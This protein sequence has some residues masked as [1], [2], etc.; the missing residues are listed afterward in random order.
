[1]KK[2]IS[3]FLSLSH[4]FCFVAFDCL[5]YYMCLCVLAFFHRDCQ[6]VSNGREEGEALRQMSTTFLDICTIGQWQRVIWETKLIFGNID[7][8]LIIITDLCLSLDVCGLGMVTHG[9]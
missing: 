6:N 9:H 2:W 1:M 8:S 5:N 3:F 4:Y 7:T